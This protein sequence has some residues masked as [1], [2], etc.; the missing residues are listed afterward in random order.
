MTT[1]QGMKPN[2]ILFSPFT[3]DF[4]LKTAT[5]KHIM[6][7]VWYFGLQIRG[8]ENKML[9]VAKQKL[10]DFFY[11]AR[12]YDNSHLI[13]NCH[14]VGKYL[15]SDHKPI[16]V[17]NNIASSYCRNYCWRSCWLT[18]KKRVW[19]IHHSFLRIIRN[20]FKNHVFFEKDN[21]IDRKHSIRISLKVQDRINDVRDEIILILENMLQGLKVSKVT[22]FFSEIYQCISHLYVTFEDEGIVQM[23]MGGKSSIIK[24]FHQ[25]TGW[26]IDINTWYPD[27]INQ[28]VDTKKLHKSI[29]LVSVDYEFYKNKNI[30]SMTQNINNIQDDITETIQKLLESS[31]LENET[32]ALAAL[33]NSGICFILNA[34]NRAVW[35]ILMKNQPFWNNMIWIKKD[36]FS[37]YKSP[38]DSGST[39]YDKILSEIEDLTQFAFEI[40]R[41]KVEA[42]FKSKMMLKEGSFQWLTP[43]FN[44][45]DSGS[46]RELKEANRDLL[47]MINDSK[48]ARGV[49]LDY[50]E[51]QRVFSYQT[52]HPTLCVHWEKLE[53]NKE[54]KGSSSEDIIAVELNV[55]KASEFYLEYYFSPKKLNDRLDELNSLSVKMFGQFFDMPVKLSIMQ[56]LNVNLSNIEHHSK[57]VK[58]YKPMSSKDGT[59][60]FFDIMITGIDIVEYSKS[61]IFDLLVKQ[62]AVHYKDFDQHKILFLDS[63]SLLNMVNNWKIIR[64]NDNA[65]EKLGMVVLLRFKKVEDALK[66]YTKEK[67]LCLP[68]N[69]GTKGHPNI[70]LSDKI[71]SIISE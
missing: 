69:D 19:T 25:V 26:K 40:S 39:E 17:C 30:N 4:V 7:L 67:T 21:N 15:D 14:G 43:K 37:K 55:D 38:S 42:D 65:M 9:E 60:R 27:L 44:D 41:Q 22:P 31:K 20:M 61:G 54:N 45:S 12:D 28:E 24:K 56:E 34:S 66:F 18:D 5:D 33:E 6:F 3:P 32:F 10:I 57:R 11:F 59:I 1:D 70:L 2:G 50:S 36:E 68:L 46:S 62:L 29:F 51:D 48:H 58:T 8:N 49:K 47:N 71:I 63:L 64:D 53:A 13:V 52:F 35:D 16:K 23:I